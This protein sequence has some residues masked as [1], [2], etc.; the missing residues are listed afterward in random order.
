M[1]FFNK[2]PKEPE[3]QYYD[4]KTLVKN[5]INVNGEK[6]TFDALLRG[7]KVKIRF[8]HLDYVLDR[9]EFNKIIR[10]DGQV[11]YDD[12]YIETLIA[13]LNSIISDQSLVETWKIQG[14]PGIEIIEVDVNIAFNQVIKDINSEVT[15]H[16]NDLGRDIS[17]ILDDFN[18]Y[19]PNQA[20]EILDEY[21]LFIDNVNAFKNDLRNLRNEK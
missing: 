18:K 4:W 14:L 20:T 8:H 1:G 5:T 7:R 2:K 17:T 3:F 10:S 19:Y 9:G 15:R 16:F 13:T 21:N 6:R 11:D 12:S